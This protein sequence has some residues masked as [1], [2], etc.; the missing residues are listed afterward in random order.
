M[1]LKRPPFNSSPLQS[2]SPLRAK[3]SKRHAVCCPD[4]ENRLSSQ[5][6]TTLQICCE[7]CVQLSGS[8]EVD[9]QTA[10][11]L[12]VDSSR[13]QFIYR[14]HLLLLYFP[15]SAPPPPWP[16]VKFA[17]PPKTS[18]RLRHS[19]DGGRTVRQPSP[20]QVIVT[21]DGRQ[22]RERVCAV[23]PCRP[24]HCRISA[25]SC[26][27]APARNHTISYRSLQPLTQIAYP[28]P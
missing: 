16:A 17:T 2:Q 3:R 15:L 12:A 25:S 27:S 6:P 21:Q 13:V 5:L 24:W 4:S 28:Q 22:R 20:A 19:L 1:W 9:R 18:R 26:P 10:S 14:A 11:R 8:P 23:P 7:P